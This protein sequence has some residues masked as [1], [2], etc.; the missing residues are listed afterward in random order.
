LVSLLGPDILCFSSDYPHWDN[1]M[2]GATLQSLP[3]DVRKAVFFDNAARA[4]RL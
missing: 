3:P 2:P 4:L 1:E